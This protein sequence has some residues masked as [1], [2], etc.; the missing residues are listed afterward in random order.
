VLHSPVV[1]VKSVVYESAGTYW[2]AYASMAPAPSFN[3]SGTIFNITFHVIDLGSCNIEFSMYKFVDRDAIPIDVEVQNG[4]FQNYVPPPPPP[5]KISVSPQ[6]IIDPT[7]DICKNFSVQINLEDVIDLYEFEFWL[8]YN[9]TILDVYDIYINETFEPNIETK[10]FEDK[11]LL[12]ASGWL[13]S[14]S[15]EGSFMLASITFHVTGIGETPLDLFNVSLINSSGEPI[16]MLEPAD[17]YFNNI[18]MARLFVKPEKLIAPQLKPGSIFNISILIENA[19]DLYAYHFNLTY[20]TNILTCI[21]ILLVPLSN[22]SSVST[23]ANWK[24]EIGNI[25]V[26]VTYEPPAEPITVTSPKTIVI[27]YFMVENY[28]STILDLKDTRLANPEGKNIVHEAGDGYFCTV[29]R[30]IAITQIVLSKNATYAGRPIIINVTISN[31]GD[32]AENFTLTVYYNQSIIGIVNITELGPKR[33]I[34]ITLTWDTSGLNACNRYV[35]SAEISP[36]PYELDLSNNWLVGG[37]VKIK[38]LG[39]VNGDGVI[40]MSDIVSATSIY[41]AEEGDPCWNPEA[42]V[43][44]PYGI[45]DIADVVTI[46]SKYGKGC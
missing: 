12:K 23:E 31:R 11:G 38:M 22:E 36:V 37:T 39:D 29:I 27:I 15:L 14:P 6:K 41:G 42:D 16:D 8:S 45:I 28:G 26:N 19:I 1:G 4:Y 43:A 13:T 17:G 20:D 7:L 34:T 24:D 5:A 25:W 40:D 33:N 35:I 21:G 44:E 46:A 32:S 30:E 9:T 10:I 2:C 18:L 3:G